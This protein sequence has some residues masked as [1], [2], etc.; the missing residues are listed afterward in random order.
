MCFIGQIGTMWRDI[1]LVIHEK[2]F[3]VDAIDQ[4]GAI[5]TFD[6]QVCLSH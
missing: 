1:A 4:A 6:L 3:Q 2:V 5:D